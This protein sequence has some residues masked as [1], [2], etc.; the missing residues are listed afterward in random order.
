M[1]GC[2][3]KVGDAAVI[4]TTARRQIIIASSMSDG[5]IDI[6]TSLQYSLQAIAMGPKSICSNIEDD[7]ATGMVRSVGH[8]GGKVIFDQLS[9]YFSKI[10]QLASCC[11]LKSGSIYDQ[12]FW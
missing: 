11:V 9:S 3:I 12:L 4:I 5:N 8:W 7:M 1:C 6:D 2:C 10:D